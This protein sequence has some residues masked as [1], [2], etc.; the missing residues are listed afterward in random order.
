MSPNRTHS[1]SVSTADITRPYGLAYDAGADRLFVADGSSHVVA[2]ADVTGPTFA[3]STLGGYGTDSTTEGLYVPTDVWVDGS[4]D[5]L[6]LDTGNGEL[7]RYAYDASSDAYSYDGDFLSGSRDTFAGT[8]LSDPVALAGDG[9]DC[10]VLDSGNQRVVKLDLASGTATD[11]VTGGGWTD[12]NGLAVD[13]SGTIYVSDT[14]DDLVTVH[15]GSGGPIGGTGTADG[16]FRTPVGLAVDGSDHLFVLDDGNRR[17]QEFDASRTHVASFGNPGEFGSGH[18]LAVGDSAV[19]LSDLSRGAIHEYATGSGGPQ[20]RIDEG[21][22]DFGSLETGYR[23]R[24]TV[25]VHNDGGTPLS[26]TDVTAEGAAFEARTGSLTVAPDDSARIEVA[27]APTET[28][29]ASGQLLVE[30][31]GTGD[32]R[33]SVVLL[34]R[35][36]EPTTLEAALVLDRSGSMRQ[37]AGPQTKMAQLHRAAGTFVDLMRAGAG[38]RLAIVGFDDS[39]SVAHGLQE[40]TESPQNTRQDARTAIQSLSPRG[41]TSIGGGV[42]TARGEFGQ[43]SDDV[44]QVL[45]VV[46]DGMENEPPYVLPSDDQQGVSLSALDDFGIHTVGLGLGSE[47]DL[48]VLQKLASIGEGGTSAESVAEGSFH[49]TEERW[50]RLQ[51]FFVEI[52]ADA[53]GEYVALDPEYRIGSQDAATLDVTLDDVDR[54]ATFAAYWDDPGATV[55]VRVHAPDGTVVDPALA[56]RTAGVRRGGTATTTFY[57]VDLPLSAASGAHAGTWTVEVRNRSH[58]DITA[59]VSVVVDSDLGVECSIHR[60]ADGTG[61]PARLDARLTEAGAPVEPDGVDVTVE[62]PAYSRG[63]L[64]A[65]V[66]TGDRLPDP[67]E[68]DREDDTTDEVTVDDADEVTVDDADEVTVDDVTTGGE[69]DPTVGGGVT[70]AVGDNTVG[71]TVVQ[72]P[73]ADTGVDWGTFTASLRTGVSGIDGPALGPDLSDWVYGE[74]FDTLDPDTE[75]PDDYGTPAVR[76]ALAEAVE[77]DPRL[78]ERVTTRPEAIEREGAAV[79]A[80]IGSLDNEGAYRV[81]AVLEYERDGRTL[82]RECRHTLATVSRP[83]PA[84]TTVEVVEDEPG[85]LVETLL[86]RAVFRDREGNLLGPGLA[87]DI[88]VSVDDGSAFD[89]VDGG[90]GSYRFRLEVPVEDARVDPSFERV[91]DIGRERA[92]AL[93]EAGFGSLSAVLAADTPSVEAVD[94]VGSTLADRLRSSATL[95]AGTPEVALTL[96]EVDLSWSLPEIR[97]GVPRR[98][99]VGPQSDLGDAT[100]V[101]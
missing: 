59:G 46:S 67:D 22:L 91:D 43:G 1:R 74:M 84:Q 101:E 55:D 89:V 4:G 76:E 100:E 20:A 57:R 35:G 75:P 30:H 52:F 61:H 50:L 83:S 31:D 88:A 94:G 93:R 18:G 98:T 56:G 82:T 65:A 51:K 3:T 16:E 73:L 99:P 80:H 92:G 33:S 7:D 87:D 27:F 24:A 38:D 17:I 71:E 97:A 2:Y 8:A 42:S 13:G 69:S 12:P 95:M 44:R 6:V 60:D 86:V 23:L 54:T 48:P 9:S 5:L 78:R 25:T 85:D 39:A 37:D 28:E 14:A 70:G 10:Y 72:D 66:L 29:A 64:R 11:A 58:T 96:R 41:R 40:L 34:G 32:G 21:V 47:V 90:D 81:R 36:T 15:G 68:R 53:M 63:D 79:S 19:Y 62:R 26:L 49:L 45:V 77:S